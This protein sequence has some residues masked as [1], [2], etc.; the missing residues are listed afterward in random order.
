MYRE[1][2]QNFA[3]FTSLRER[4]FSTDPSIYSDPDSALSALEILSGTV[5]NDYLQGHYFLLIIFNSKQDLCRA[6]P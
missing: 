4:G 1:R 5:N 3:T 2:T 6:M